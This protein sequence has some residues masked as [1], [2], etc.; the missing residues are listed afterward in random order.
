MTDLGRRLL[1]GALASIVVACSTSTPPSSP[2]TAIIPAT[3]G[4]T[5]S[6]T[7][8]GNAGPSTPPEPGATAEP[9]SPVPTLAASP[10]PSA[11]PASPVPSEPAIPGLDGLVGRD[12]RFTMLL[13]GSD[14]RA[15]LGG[16]R[17]DTIM[18]V[19][20]D[21]AT[22][23]VAMLSLPRDTDQVPIGPGRVYGPKVNGLF[24]QFRLNS[25][26]RRSAY[27]SMMRAL[28]YTFGIEIDRYALVHFRGLV[29]IIDAMGGIDVRLAQPFIDPTSHITKRGLRL[30]AGV[31]HLDGGYALAFSRSRHTTSDYDRA[32]RQQLVIAVAVAKVLRMGIGKLATL[33]PVVFRKTE[34]NLA[35][36]DVP[37]LFGLAQ[38]ARL[39]R[40]KYVVLGPRT[41]A[42]ESAGFANQLKLGVV[43][44]LFR[45][46]FGS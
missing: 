37:A 14:A 21:P 10:E 24:Q 20:I 42:T 4:P 17:T 23:K 35:I 30:H 41:Y 45:I 3:A 43:R 46:I 9:G 29:D 31:N 27:R 34:T 38:T 11:T 6:A 26:S 39:G 36:S 40:I 33:A 25:G 19:T 22:G 7:D 2:S 28:G 1:A 44:G 5:T 12:G 18:I 15:G 8:R 13:L 16:E 32:R